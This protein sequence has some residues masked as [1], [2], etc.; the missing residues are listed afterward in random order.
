MYVFTNP[1]SPKEST[2]LQPAQRVT[3]DQVGSGLSTKRSTRGDVVG[4]AAAQ[5]NV[6]CLKT[7]NN[8]LKDKIHTMQEVPQSGN[9]VGGGRTKES[10]IGHIAKSPHRSIEACGDARENDR[11]AHGSTTGWRISYY[12]R[13]VV[14]ESFL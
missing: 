12:I 6:A 9:G 1:K 4:R 13:A 2:S 8:I 3:Q 10:N 5:V 14:V 11:L 7:K